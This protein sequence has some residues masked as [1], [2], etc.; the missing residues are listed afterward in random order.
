MDKKLL[1][2]LVYS[3]IGKNKCKDE[4]IKYEQCLGNSEFY[5]QSPEKCED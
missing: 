1:N 4:K 5:I 3:R 2:I